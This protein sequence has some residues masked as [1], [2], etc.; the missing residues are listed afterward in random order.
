MF[1]RQMATF[2]SHYKAKNLLPIFTPAKYTCSDIVMEL[3]AHI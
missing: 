2:Y 3:A 1:L